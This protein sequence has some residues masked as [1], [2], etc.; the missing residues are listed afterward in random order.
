MIGNTPKADRRE[1]ACLLLLVLLHGKK[2]VMGGL[3]LSGKFL[4]GKVADPAV[5]VGFDGL[6][7]LIVRSHRA[8]IRG[9]VYRGILSLLRLHGIHIGDSYA[10]RSEE[11]RVG[12]E[13]L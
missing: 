12:K 10:A 11:R 5:V 9:E 3:Y 7:I 13:C 8:G 6:Q 2:V 1:T 4:L